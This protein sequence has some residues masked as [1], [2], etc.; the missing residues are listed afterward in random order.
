MPRE[1]IALEITRE[2]VFR[3]ANGTL[4]V[5]YRVGDTV[6]ASAKGAHYYVTPMGGIW[7]NEATEK[8]YDTA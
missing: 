5:K 8:Q 6:F 3:D 4:L 7:F 2:V 1:R